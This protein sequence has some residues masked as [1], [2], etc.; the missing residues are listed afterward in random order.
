QIC[1]HSDRLEQFVSGC[2]E[3]GVTGSTALLPTIGL[4]RGA[5]ALTFMDERVAGI[6]IPEALIRRVRQ[7]ADE[8]EAAYQM[9]LEQAQ[10]ALSLPGVSG[11]H[12]SDFRHDGSIARLVSD[13]GLGSPISAPASA[14]KNEKVEEDHAHG[15]EL[16]R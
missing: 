9:A 12:L 15:S 8:S 11:I 4:M 10:H 14:Q 5:G 16:A 13:L 6:S 2:V 1:Y 7:S 3:R